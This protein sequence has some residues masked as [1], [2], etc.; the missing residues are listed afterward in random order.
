MIAPRSIRAL[1][2]V[3]AAV[4]LGLVQCAG[5]SAVASDLIDTA[6]TAIVLDAPAPGESQVW[7]MSVKNVAGSPVPLSL[8]ITGRSDVLFSG[9]APMELTINTPDGTAVVERIRVGE[10]LGRTITLPELQAGASYSLV[11]TVTLPRV[12]DNSYQGA[13]GHLKF[14]FVSSIDRPNVTPDKPAS[15]PDLANTGLRNLIPVGVAAAVLLAVGFG[16]ILRSSKEVR[17]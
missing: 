14:H 8:E 3:I 5:A 7:N 17:S 1:I 9:A 11:G 13:S 2:A 4:F 6:P 15:G 12:A 10:V 16:L